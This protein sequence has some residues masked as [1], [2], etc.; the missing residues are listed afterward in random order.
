M[1]SLSGTGGITSRTLQLLEDAEN[2]VVF[3]A[4][5][6]SLATD[7]TVEALADAAARG[8]DVL[9]GTVT[10]SLR[11]E[12]AERVPDAEIFR[13]ELEWLHADAESGVAIGR[14]LLVDQSTI[15]LSSFEEES[16][17]EKAI[18]GRGFKNGLVI[19]TRRL[20]ATGL[21]A[22]RDPEE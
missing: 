7:E 16:R 3:I 17:E 19:I 21:L 15:L 11:E 4:S 20:M 6:E 18:F 2:E 22:T 9:I 1:W 5:E 12:L 8:V 10:E 14:M 13:S